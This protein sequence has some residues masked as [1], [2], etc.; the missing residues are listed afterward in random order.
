MGGTTTVLTPFAYQIL[1]RAGI[2]D[3]RIVTIMYD[4]VAD[5]K[6]N[7]FPGKLFND[8]NHN[9]DVYKGT[10]LDYT[11]KEV[12][13]ELVLAALKGDKVKV[14]ELTGREGKVIDS[15][16]D[17]NVFMAVSDHRGPGVLLMPDRLM[18][19]KELN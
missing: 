7:P 10:P 2:P 13:V 19:A 12:T 4:D 5:D 17:D 18:T 16:P 14:K 8:Y 6:K 15:G 3:E 11:S 1:H 9:P